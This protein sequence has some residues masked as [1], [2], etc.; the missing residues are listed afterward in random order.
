MPNVLFRLLCL[1]ALFVGSYVSAQPEIAYQRPSDSLTDLVSRPW[2]SLY[3]PSPDRERLL[4]LGLKQLIPPEVLQREEISLAGFHMYRKTRAKSR[5]LYAHEM[6]LID[7][8][9]GEEQVISGLPDNPRILLIKWSPDSNYV[10]AILDGRDQTELWL[11]DVTGLNAKRL[12]TP[13]ILAGMDDMISWSGDSEH[14]WIKTVPDDMGPAPLQKAGARGAIIRQTSGSAIPAQTFQ[15]TLKTQL[16]VE[17]FEYYFSSVLTRVNINDSYETVGKRGIY[18][19]FRES[20]DQQNILVERLV[21]PWSY[22]VNADQ[23]AFDVEVWHFESGNQSL[24]TSSPL[25]EALPYG[26]GNVRRGAR[27]Y[28]WRSDQPATVVWVEALDNGDPYESVPFRD[29]VMSIEAPFDGEPVELVK[30]K[31]RVGDIL[32]ND[33]DRAILFTWDWVR[34]ELEISSFN[35]NKNQ[36]SVRT[37]VSFEMGDRYGHPGL[38]LMTFNERGYPVVHTDDSGNHMYLVGEG[39]SSEGN[40]PFIDKF[41]FDNRRKKRLFRSRKPY[42]E[43]PITVLDNKGDHL[44]IRRESKVMP[45]SYFKWS[46]RGGF[47][48]Q[49]T[50]DENPYKELEDIQRV[51]LEYKRRDGVRLTANLYLPKGYSARK[52]GPLPTL[53][54]AYPKAYQSAQ[55]A[56]QMKKSPYQFL[57]GRWNRPIIWATQ[58]FAVLDDPTMPII[59]KAEGNANDTFIPQIV[60]S[61]EAAVKE[62]LRRGVSERGKIALG[63]HSYGAFMT[64]NLLAHTDL[65]EVGIARGGAYNRTLT[66]FGFQSEERNLWQAPR[67]YLE[68]SPFLNASHID[69]PLLLLHGS[70]DENPG[71]YPM[72]SERLFHALNGLGRE[73]RLVMFPDEGHTFRGENGVL[74]SLWEMERW[75]ERHIKGESLPTKR[76]V[77]RVVGSGGTSDDALSEGEEK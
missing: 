41:N 31:G 45:P 72:Q 23:F 14:I 54:W 38:P 4:Q 56:G 32:W 28:D 6:A 44:L 47:H 57:H 74:H 34:R 46:R 37:L 73:A 35:P 36:K 42:F 67:V 77:S 39:A 20:P 5:R 63:G 51:L 26:G 62:L 59:A 48:S 40:R 61:A 3:N 52:N 8:Q 70:K 17:L 2:P 10:G 25:A 43:T 12:N 50:F 53:I 1:V 66:P 55:N 76:I 15:G 71:T 75:L 30:T 19:Y 69:E 13:P 49:V 33:S 65:F 64:A 7:I 27:D 18:G 68:M 11:I 60:D 29:Q 9:T 58:G 22:W 24:I 21:E 16:D